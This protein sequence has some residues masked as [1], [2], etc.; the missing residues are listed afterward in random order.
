MKKIVL[1][2]TLIFSLFSMAETPRKAA[3]EAL[4]KKDA[5]AIY[6]NEESTDAQI[7]K[8]II[9]FEKYSQNDPKMLYYLG[10][11]NIEK[12][13]KMLQLDEKAG[14]N[15]IEQAAVRGDEDAKYEYSM[16]LMKNG[17]LKDGIQ[18]LKDAALKN[19]KNAQ[20]QL[21]KMFYQGN[22]VPLNKTNGFNLI[23]AAAEQEHPD[24]QYDLAKIFFAQSSETLQKGGIHWLNKAVSN[25][26]YKAC[27]DLYKIYHAGILVEQ[28]LQK[29]LKFLN[30][31]A[32][33]DNKDAQLLLA[34]YYQNGKYVT[35]NEHSAM[36]WYEKLKESGNAEG[37]YQFAVYN[38]KYKS[39]QPIVVRDSLS[40]LDKNSKY[41]LDSANL[42]AQ[43]YMK[44]LYGT[45]MSFSTAVLHLENAK[46]LGDPSAQNKIIYLLSEQ[47]KIKQKN[48]K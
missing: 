20:Y 9:I 19:Q 4:E 45:R 15:Y 36:I 48:K 22:G 23:K 42:M 28:N 8:A 46:N 16:E 33:N 29:H 47:D 21:G 5:V 3:V 27:D 35:K 1:V 37:I 26:N 40:L 17:N 11:A 7:A 41:H 34:S 39:E 12:R 43:I 14:H 18:S 24:A 25:K 13:T 30:C 32:L 38:L 6:N 31:S 10:K 2:A 44:G